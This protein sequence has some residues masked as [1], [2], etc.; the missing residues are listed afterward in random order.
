MRDHNS[1]SYA[2]VYSLVITK[3]WRNR[4]KHVCFSIVK[5]E[6]FSLHCSVSDHPVVLLQKWPDLQ[7]SPKI[8]D[9]MH[10]RDL[11]GLS[12]CPRKTSSSSTPTFSWYRYI[13]S[14]AHDVHVISI[15]DQFCKRNIRSTD[16]KDSI[17]Q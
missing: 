8:I 6:T 10:L 1:L 3:S 12:Y 15:V 16:S 11:A 9:I 5:H 7:K 17:V 14:F 13:P 2:T 4:G